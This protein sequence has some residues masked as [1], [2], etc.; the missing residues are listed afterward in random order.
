MLLTYKNLTIRNATQEDAPFLCRW[1]NDGNVMAHAGFP[2][3]LNTNVDKIIQALSSDSDDTYRRL[4]I[5][6]DG[7]P[8]GEMNYRNKGNCVAGIGTKICE[9]DKQE[10]GNGTLFLKMLIT[11]LFLSGYRKISLD[12]NLKNTRAQHVY[13]KLGFKKLRVHYDSWKDQ[14][15]VLQSFVDYELLP[16]DFTP[17]FF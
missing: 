9:A 1:W 11:H 17:L 10:K 12:T 13:E 2:N 8:I 7:L 4:I 16:T 3:G 6:E 15:G 5:E 14:S